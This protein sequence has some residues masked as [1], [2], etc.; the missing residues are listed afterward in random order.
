[1]NVLLRDQMDITAYHQKYFRPSCLPALKLR[2]ASWEFFQP[3]YAKTYDQIQVPTE[4]TKTPEDTL[5][6]YFSI[7]REASNMGGR[8]CGSIGYGRIPFPLAYNFLSNKY[9]EKFSYEEYLNSFDGVGHTSLIKLCQ[10]PDLKQGIKFFYEIETIEEFEG[11]RAEYFGYSYGFIHL[12]HEQDGFRISDFQQI[13]EDFLCAPYHLWQHDGEAVVDV[14]YGIWC[15]LIQKRYPTIINGY[16]K[17]IYFHGNDGAD[18]CFIFITL[19]NG[20]DIEIA[21]FR[22]VGDEKWKQVKMKPEAECRG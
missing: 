3:Y 10:V 7:L 18:Y 16:G 9:Q 17:H 21:Q 1:M 4:L 2:L 22:K 6:N 13:P 11:K 12:V 20:T 14:K 8:S 19:T 15:K 5:I